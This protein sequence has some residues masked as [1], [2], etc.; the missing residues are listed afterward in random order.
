M[1]VPIVSTV[2]ATRLAAIG[3]Y[4]G[5]IEKSVEVIGESHNSNLSDIQIARS[6]HGCAGNL[7]FKSHKWPLNCLIM[8]CLLS[9]KY[10]RTCR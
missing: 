1:R 2:S 3:G 5:K 8:I 6:G 4:S 7:A 10:S 9:Q